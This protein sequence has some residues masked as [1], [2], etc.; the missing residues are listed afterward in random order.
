MDS[1]INFIWDLF[2]KSFECKDSLIESTAELSDSDKIS[3][4]RES[5]GD[6]N[7]WRRIFKE[8]K[9]N[10]GKNVLLARKGQ[11][12]KIDRV[13]FHSR[14]GWI[15]YGDELKA[16]LGKSS[17][18]RKVRIEIG[19]RTYFSGHSLLLG[20]GI[21]KIGSYC[22]VAENLYANVQPDYHPFKYPSLFNFKTEARLRGDDL[23]MLLTFNGDYEKAPRGINI[24]SD[25][26]VARNVRIFNG[27]RIGTGCVI[28]EGSLVRDDCEP[29]GIYAGVPAKLIRYRFKKRI[30][31]ELLE[32]SWWDWPEEK[33]LKNRV[34]FDTNLE[35]FDGD[36]IDL[37]EA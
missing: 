5:M 8:R 3:L 32:T 20:D 24:G 10:L 33:V 27:V 15:L 28:A 13:E 29:Y 14:F 31:E 30:I 23:S 6:L 21:F 35:V 18:F 22:A 7:I 36:V 37:I 26:W 9:K 12:I 16:Y 2:I 25:V 4:V 11:L 1:F 19:H 17:I 34:F